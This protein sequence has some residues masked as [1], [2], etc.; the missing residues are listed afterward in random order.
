MYESLANSRNMRTFAAV[1][2]MVV[3]HSVRANGNRSRQE[4]S[5]FYWLNISCIPVVYPYAAAIQKDLCALRSTAIFRTTGCAAAPFISSR[6]V[7]KAI[8]KEKKEIWR[9]IKGYEGKYQVSNYGRVK[10]LARCFVSEKGKSYQL[11][12]ETIMRPKQA[13][14]G[15]LR[16][17]LFDGKTKKCRAIHRLVAQ[18]FLDDYNEDYVV[19]HLDEDPTNNRVENLRCMTAAE[20]NVYG[21][22]R[23]RAG[24]S[25]SLRLKDPVEQYSLDGKLLAT[26]KSMC[27]AD[28]ATGV[29]YKSISAACRCKCRTA[30]GYRWAKVG[31]KVHYNPDRR[32][33]KSRFRPMETVGTCP[34]CVDMEG[35]EWRPIEGF[36]GIYEVSNMGR[37]RSLDRVI[38]IGGT[39]PYG[40]HGSVISQRYTG[41]IFTVTLNQGRKSKGF[42]V[43]RLVAKA[44]VDG[45]FDGAEVNHKDEDPTN[46]R[47]D[48]LEWCNNNYNKKYGTAKQRMIESRSHPV[49]QCDMQG[50]L[51]HEYPTIKDAAAA[52]GMK[53]DKTLRLCCQGLR[54]QAYGY[55]W[56]YKKDIMSKIPTDEQKIL[57]IVEQVDKLL[58]DEQANMAESLAVARYVAV[59]SFSDMADD[60]KTIK[61]RVALHKAGNLVADAI[62]AAIHQRID[63]IRL[64]VGRA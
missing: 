51:L 61:E 29:P 45:Y 40:Y 54:G 56:K 22:A 44:F 35:E 30:G 23:W 34:N 24:R 55:I 21:T 19:N 60:V 64:P 63:G 6:L 58:A 53:Y 12:G 20:N 39:Q 33:H 38:M 48:N 59:Q 17:G 52:V 27:E 16:V 25:N 62:R 8:M 43:H 57:R 26:Y 32:K 31:Y 13:E 46:N 41:R 42:S 2:K 9:D 11:K 50:N 5:L 14:S 18:A 3:D 47:A 4:V 37:V 7:K 49:L 15:H 36:E 10:S 28:R 1:L